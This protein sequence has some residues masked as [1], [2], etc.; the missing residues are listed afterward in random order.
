LLPTTLRRF[1]TL[2]GAPL[3]LGACAGI[4]STFTAYGAEA[5][6]TRAL[7]LVM[8]AG[9]AMITVAVLWL[10]RHAVRSPANR[11]DHQGGMRVILWLGAIGPTLILATLLASTLPTMRTLAAKPGDLEIQVE[12]K[13][14][15]WRVQYRPGGDDVVE[16]ANEIRVPVGRAVTFLLASPDVIHSF[17]IPGLAG[18]MDM[19]PG[20][21]NKLVVQATGE[22]RYRGACAEF[23]GLSHARMAFEVVAMEAAAF[24]GWLAGQASPA[25]AGDPHGK[26]LFDAYGCVGCHQVRGQ[27]QGS[28]IGPDLTHVGSRLSL[29]AGTLPLTPQA[30]ADF[31]RDPAASKPG[32]LMPSFRD[33]A[34]QDAQAIAAWLMALR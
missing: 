9:A 20:R 2:T 18:K 34:P 16:T 11:L 30:L 19:I 10:A 3:L 13:Q 22:G 33:M 8:A 4:Q 21:T 27:L 15:W 17:W 24:E 28:R 7:T 6:S 23:C 32:A 5:A 31:I 14:F 29:G 26:E 12:G 25:A 1:A